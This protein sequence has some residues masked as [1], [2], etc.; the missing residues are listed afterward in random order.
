[1][2]RQGRADKGEGIWW[3]LEPPKNSNKF[4]PYKTGSDDG[5]VETKVVGDSGGGGSS[6]PT[7]L[8]TKIKKKR[9]KNRKKEREGPRYRDR[10]LFGHDL[11][12]PEV[13]AGGA[14]L[15]RA[16]R[17]CVGS[18]GVGFCFSGSFFLEYL[19]CWQTTDKVF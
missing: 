11:P 13:R 4:P 1:M 15:T 9:E 12:H 3:R 19:E 16:E 17:G 6:D 14:A 8:D 18:G 7:D 5:E 2:E 10:A